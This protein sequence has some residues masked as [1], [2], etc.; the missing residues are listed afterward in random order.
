MVR[1]AGMID[2][3]ASKKVE[4]QEKVKSFAYNLTVLEF[5]AMI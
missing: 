1:K 5:Y 4:L 3:N 2:I